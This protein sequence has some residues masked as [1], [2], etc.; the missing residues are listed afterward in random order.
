MSA[1]MIN[2]RYGMENDGTARLINPPPIESAE[3]SA[4]KGM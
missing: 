3:K 2:R 4:R 1:V